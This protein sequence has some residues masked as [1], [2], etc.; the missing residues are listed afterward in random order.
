[1]GRPIVGATLPSLRVRL[2]VEYVVASDGPYRLKTRLICSCAYNSL[3]NRRGK[4]SPARFTVWTEEG[5]Q[6]MRS[7]S[8]IAE[9]TVLI[10]LTLCR[11]SDDARARASSTRTTEPPHPSVTKISKT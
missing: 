10:K 2:Q 7:N 11:C 1:M 3:T 4:D 8:A 9:G 5:R 6:P